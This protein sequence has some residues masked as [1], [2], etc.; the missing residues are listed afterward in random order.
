LFADLGRAGQTLMFVGL[1]PYT[2]VLG[3][4]PGVILEFNSEVVALAPHTR[5]NI[6]SLVLGQ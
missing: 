6:A 3:Y 5:N 4:A 1:A 2:M